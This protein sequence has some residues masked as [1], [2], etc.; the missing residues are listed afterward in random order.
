MKGNV[1]L[2]SAVQSVGC[3]SRI[4]PPPDLT[5]GAP[6][7]EPSLFS[8]SPL[9]AFLVEVFRV[10]LVF[11]HLM[12]TSSFIRKKGWFEMQYF[13]NALTREGTYLRISWHFVF[14]YLACVCFS[15]ASPYV[16]TRRQICKVGYSILSR[17]NMFYSQPVIYYPYVS[18]SL[19]YHL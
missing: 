9:M 3:N 6:H 2:E 15:V 12:I 14:Q 17:P 11:A 5:A 18:I 7:L 4:D 8:V 13:S 16:I 1:Y 10:I 19:C